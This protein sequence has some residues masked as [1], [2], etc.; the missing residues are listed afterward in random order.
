MIFW[1][2]P[3]VM[4]WVEKQ[5]R[6]EKKNSLKSSEQSWKL[7]HSK[8]KVVWIDIRK[9]FHLCVNLIVFLI[10]I[11]TI[12]YPSSSLTWSSSILS[13]QLPWSSS[14]SSRL[15]SSSS[16]GKFSEEIDQDKTMLSSLSVTW[17]IDLQLLHDQFNHQHYRHYHHDQSHN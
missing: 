11:M 5:K 13:S 9:L 2:H 10:H 3:L 7:I 12:F 4:G 16:W 1:H 6:N 17:K 15:S 8:H 14:S